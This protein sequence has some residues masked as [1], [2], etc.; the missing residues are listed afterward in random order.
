[1]S[2][3]VHVLRRGDERE[4]KDFL[5][6]L[7][8]PPSLLGGGEIYSLSAHRV[9]HLFL[10]MWGQRRETESMLSVSV[11]SPETSGLLPRQELSSLLLS[12]LIPVMR[13]DCFYIFIFHV[14]TQVPQKQVL[15]SWKCKTIKLA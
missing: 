9:R 8:A 3:S 15:P 7:L 11:T 5:Q 1:M 14:I 4:G 6:A 12:H 2:S 10:G 13:T